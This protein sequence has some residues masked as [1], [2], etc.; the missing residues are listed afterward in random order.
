MPGVR[1]IRCV[2]P[3]TLV[4]FC[5]RADRDE[6]NCSAEAFISAYAS[7]LKRSGKLEVP[8]WVDLVKTGSFKE[9]AP[10]DPDWYYVRAGP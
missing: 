8:T 3:E 5:A 2:L 9:L 4:E 6:W 1:D 10:Y 7:H